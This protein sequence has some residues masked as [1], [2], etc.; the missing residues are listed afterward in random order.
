MLFK[1]RE[2]LKEIGVN[3]Q[4]YGRKE[5]S[6]S[7]NVNK[8]IKLLDEV[9]NSRTKGISKTKKGNEVEVNV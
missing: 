5:Y 8:F 7:V 1:H 6:S 3:A 9:V 2:R 4:E